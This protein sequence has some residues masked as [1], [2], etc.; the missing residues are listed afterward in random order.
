MKSNLN[1]GNLKDLKIYLI[2]KSKEELLHGRNVA[3]KKCRRKKCYKEEMSK[4]EMLQ[5]RNVARKK[6]RK[7]EN[8]QVRKVARM[9]CRKG[10]VAR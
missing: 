5:G 3:R 1:T 9:K 4:E 6:F 2:V 10:N 7:T 8:S